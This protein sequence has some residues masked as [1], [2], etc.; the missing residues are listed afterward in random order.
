MLSVC[1]TERSELSRVHGCRAERRQ[2]LLVRHGLPDYRGQHSG[3]EPPGPPLSE[4][5]RD[6]ARQA[7]EVLKGYAAA[8]IY[9]S[10][11][12]RAVQTAEWIRAITFVPLRI[13]SELKEW[14]RT[15]R[16]YEVSQRSARW[17]VRWLAGPEPGAIVVGHASPLLA[18]LR[19]ALYLPHFVWHAPG[20]PEVLRVSSCDRFE[21]SMGSITLL[22]ID[23][24]YVTATMLFH[25]EPRV[26][27]TCSRPARRC[28]P[29]PVFGHG[30]N[31]F[32]RRPNMLNLIGYRAQAHPAG[33]Q[34]SRLG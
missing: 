10:P 17:L 1:G 7:A 33:E 20:R 2:L 11:L 26:I 21:I 19:S 23:P 15:E 18:I 31:A 14:H 25:P 13:D 6:Q 24:R 29:R 27:D 32:V 28:L 22:E 9:S 16:L 4:V 34:S 3:D 30:E 5:G 12:T 8:R